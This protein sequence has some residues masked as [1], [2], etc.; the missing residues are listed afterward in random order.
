VTDVTEIVRWFNVA[1]AL[2]IIV[3]GTAQAG[4][5]RGFTADERLHWQSTALFNLTALIGTCESL[6]DGVRGGLRVYALAIAL[7]WLLAVVLRRP[8]RR[9]RRRR[10]HPREEST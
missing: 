8:L 1:A 4:R 6:R 9:W 5:W 2:L 10:R 3:V 7:C